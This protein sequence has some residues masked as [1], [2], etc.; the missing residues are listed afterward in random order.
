MPHRKELR[1]LAHI[2]ALAG[3]AGANLVQTSARGLN[4]NVCEQLARLVEA[5]AHAALAFEFALSPEW[6]T[7]VTLPPDYNP[8]EGF[9]LDP[10][11][12]EAARD[13]A[14][15]LRRLPEPRRAVVIGR[16]VKLASQTNPSDA[17]STM[18]ER[19]VGL[20]WSSEEPKL[21]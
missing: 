20:L 1:C 6:K 9:V 8:D 19:E 10:K 13:A 12:V 15:E 3:M 14:R 11:H 5:T 2:H 18:G 16:V 7:P 4:A 21:P 17:N